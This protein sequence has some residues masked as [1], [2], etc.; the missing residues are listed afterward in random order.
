MIGC[1]HFISYTGLIVVHDTEVSTGSPYQ[2]LYQVPLPVPEFGY[3][4]STRGACTLRVILTC[5]PSQLRPSFEKAESTVRSVAVVCIAE[6]YHELNHVADLVNDPEQE[7]IT[8]EV[9]K[10]T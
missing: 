3:R 6:R 1:Y 2:L 8:I 4:V 10:H 9:C 5:S 7:I